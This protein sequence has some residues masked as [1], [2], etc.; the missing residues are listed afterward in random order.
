[1]GSL[2]RASHPAPA[3]LPLDVPP[4]VHVPRFGVLLSSDARQ[5]QESY[6][7]QSQMY[8][9]PKKQLQPGDLTRLRSFVESSHVL[10]SSLGPRSTCCQSIGMKLFGS[11]DPPPPHLS[12]FTSV[13]RPQVAFRKLEGSGPREMSTPVAGQLR[14]V[15]RSS[16]AVGRPA[17]AR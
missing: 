15:L 12:P 6:N 9:H 5:N 2:G 11:T 1:M 8:R 10:T 14:W 13:M 16:G 7:Q 4:S 17:R 3:G